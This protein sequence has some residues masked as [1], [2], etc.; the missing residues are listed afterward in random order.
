MPVEIHP[1]PQYVE[2]VV[3]AYWKN[4]MFV[5]PIAGGVNFQPRVALNSI[6]FKQDADGAIEQK[7]QAHGVRIWLNANGGGTDICI[8]PTTMATKPN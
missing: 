8:S 6:A 1:A 2:P 5:C 7:R 3:N 4:N